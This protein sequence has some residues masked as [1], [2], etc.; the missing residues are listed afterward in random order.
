MHCDSKSTIDEVIGFNLIA[1]AGV[2]IKQDTGDL[3]NCEVHSFT[4]GVSLRV[5]GSGSATAEVV[6]SKRQ[7]EVLACEL[8]SIVMQNT[9]GLGITTEPLFIESFPGELSSGSFGL[10]RLLIDV[11]RNRH[12][13]V[14]TFQ[15]HKVSDGINTGQSIEVVGFGRGSSSSF[16]RPR[17][18]G[19]YVDF[20]PRVG[21]SLASSKKSILTGVFLVVLA[22]VAG[23]CNIGDGSG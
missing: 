2:G 21:N 10:G 20:V 14:V 17:A 16:E 18:N 5:V 6:S 15:F 4:D 23:R 13:E 22:S 19:V 8:G 11:T 1:W 3:S 12:I 7:L 9:F